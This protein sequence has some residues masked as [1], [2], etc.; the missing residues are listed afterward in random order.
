MPDS[1]QDES[2]G[3]VALAGLRGEALANAR[4]KA[5]TKAKRRVTLSLCGLGWLDETEVEDVPGARAPTASDGH[6]ALPPVR[7]A[8]ALDVAMAK[9]NDK[10][11]LLSGDDVTVLLTHADPQFR[12]RVWEYQIGETPEASLN[13]MATLIR[14]REEKTPRMIAH[15][16]TEIDRRRMA[17][18]GETSKGAA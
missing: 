5:E 6:A 9:W 13:T 17:L 15:L 4:M 3:V 16:M 1:R 11:A 2:T 10:D 12:A 7:T 18:A 8:A 14:S